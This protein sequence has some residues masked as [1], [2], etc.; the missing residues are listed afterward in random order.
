M[1]HCGRA[2]FIS[3][4][5]RNSHLNAEIMEKINFPF[6]CKFIKEVFSKCSLLFNSTILK[7]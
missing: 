5:G 4:K 1:S 7:S 2:N 3:E 6:I